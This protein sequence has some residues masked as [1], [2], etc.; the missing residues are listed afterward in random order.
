MHSLNSSHQTILTILLEIISW[1][2]LTLLSWLS[3]LYGSVSM[4]QM[5]KLTQSD[6]SLCWVAWGNAFRLP[7]QP[8]LI[9]FLS[10][11]NN[12]TLSGRIIKK[13]MLPATITKWYLRYVP[14][15]WVSRFCKKSTINFHTIFWECLPLTVAMAGPF[16]CSA[17]V[18]DSIC[19]Q[20]RE[21]N[22]A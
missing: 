1:R 6:A 20:T 5:S 21:E 12:F 4:C 11:C 22:S 7:K 3:F 18:N 13:T 10:I 14:C 16:Y 9:H 2:T 17:Y 8:F 19:T 15:A